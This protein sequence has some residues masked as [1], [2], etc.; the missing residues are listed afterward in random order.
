MVDIAVDRLHALNM[1]NSGVFDLMLWGT[2][3]RNLYRKSCST[4]HPAFQRTPIIAMTMDI[5]DKGNRVLFEFG[6]ADVVQKP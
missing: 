2:S 3:T 6:M 1:V 5:H 4:S